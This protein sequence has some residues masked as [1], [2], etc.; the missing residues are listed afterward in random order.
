M[1][2]RLLFRVSL[3]SLISAGPAVAA[4]VATPEPTY[5]SPLEGFVQVASLDEVE[6]PSDRRRIEFY[7]GKLLAAM[8]KLAEDDAR[9]ADGG[10]EPSEEALSEFR[11]AIVRF[12]EAADRAGLEG[13]QIAA[14]LTEAYETG[15]EGPPPINLLNSQQKLDAASL[16]TTSIG[17]QKFANANRNRQ[18]DYLSAVAVEGS[19]TR[20]ERL[21]RLAEEGEEV[22]DDAELMA[23]ITGTPEIGEDTVS[24][25]EDVSEVAVDPVIA[26]IQER[27]TF[28]GTDRVIVIERG[29]TLGLIARAI[30]G[31]G[32]LY[33]NIYSYNRDVLRN[34]DT[35]RVGI[36]L[37]LPES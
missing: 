11:S 33:R 13:P 25:V 5:A 21:S 6:N 30:Y 18:V 9:V 29:D 14:V 32:L 16:V 31:D 4:P 35:L 8:S 24:E 26:S 23:G 22:G 15:Y 37:R 12:V 2:P 20:Q 7:V 17:F 10:G 36:T 1:L 27:I 28:D 34:P 3:I 19:K